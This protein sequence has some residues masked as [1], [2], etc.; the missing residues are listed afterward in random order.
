MSFREWTS[1]A[2]DKLSARLDDALRFFDLSSRRTVGGWM[3]TKLGIVGHSPAVLVLPTVL[4]GLLVLG[5]PTYVRSAIAVVVAALLGFVFA[6]QLR[7][8]TRLGHPIVYDFW[9]QMA[10]MAVVLAAIWIGGS[11]NYGPVMPYRHVFVPL[12]FAA[13]VA[14]VGGVL[15]LGQLFKFL[16]ATNKYPDYLKRTELFASRGAIP[17][18]SWSVAFAAV[19]MPLR[20]PLALL[21]LPALATLLAPPAW[22]PLVPIIVVSI[23]AGALLLSGLNE[24]FGIMWLL[25]QEN[26]FRGGALVISI[27][28]I[29]LAGARLAEITYVTT[30]FNSAAWWTITVLFASVYVLAWWFDYWCYRLLT[31]KLLRFLSEGK[32]SR[33]AIPYSIDACAVRTSV[34]SDDRRL[35]VHGAGRFLVLRPKDP[36]PYFQ[37]LSPARMFELLATIGAPGGKATP[38]SALIASRVTNYLTLTAALFV[39]LVGGA[40]FYLHDG[41]Q[42]HEIKVELSPPTLKLNDLML[43]RTAAVDGEPLIVVAASGGGTRA[44]VYTASIL[45]AITKSGKSD[46]IVLMSGVSGGGAALAYYAG[47]RKALMSG[48]RDAW[49]AYYETMKAPFIKDVLQS[50]TDWYMVQDGRLGMLLRDSFEER[51]KL[52]PGSQTLNEVNQFGLIFNTSLA[53][54]FV[55]P[56][57]KKPAVGDAASAP[58][59]GCSESL[60]EVEQKYRKQ[61][62]PALAGGRL[63]LTNLSFSGELSQK[64]L[65]PDVGEDLPVII[66]SPSVRLEEAAALN[67][68]FPPVFSNAAIDVGCKER[69]WVTDGGAVDNRG[70]EMMLF[71]INQAVK[72]I[73]AKGPLPKIY[74]VIADASALSKDFEQDRGVS[75]FSGAG[76]HFASHLNSEVFNEIK[77]LYRSKGAS[78]P[79][80][81][82]VMMPDI[83]RESGSFGTH[84]ML[85]NTIRVRHQ[86][87]AASSTVDSKV[88][89]DTVRVSGPEMVEVLR[90]LQSGD[91]S[92]LSK[93]GKTVTQ[94]VVKDKEHDAQW[95]AFRA[96]F[97]ESASS[98]AVGGVSYRKNLCTNE[99]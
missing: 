38:Q 71:A 13:I 70:M 45:E 16:E 87:P 77:E 9:T 74:V 94:W 2:L 8:T 88:V 72:D 56:L 27:V 30:I 98:A 95:A 23:C 84:W 68:N 48:D 65:E 39:A 43:E 57:V 28:A 78:E 82:Y 66:Q 86:R 62:S 53:G 64:P 75:S 37:A 91:V 54:N 5:S 6:W 92:C 19:A 35:Q 85:Q 20:S 52:P 58:T 49:D 55:N 81:S 22:I 60:D 76:T 97:P 61:T 10:I 25:L 12:A 90:S 14:L 32:G 63:I 42:G 15:V 83:L 36:L 79:Q 18:M 29:A 26:L 50:S 31:D 41:R 47:H 69:Y 44:A 3:D 93:D 99:Q 80:I 46:R 67:A 33:A 96:A 21:T 34:P 24:R 17:Q 89:D 51:W 40:M 4:G 73:A 7:R 1:A 11:D 59:G